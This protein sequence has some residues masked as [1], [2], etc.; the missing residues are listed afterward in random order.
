MRNHMFVKVIFTGAD[1]RKGFAIKAYPNDTFKN[2]RSKIMSQLRRG[3]L[4]LYNSK[5]LAVSGMMPGQR[6]KDLN[7]KLLHASQVIRKN[8]KSF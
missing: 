6:V 7:K 5:L 2:V 8:R 3:G 1:V 4:A